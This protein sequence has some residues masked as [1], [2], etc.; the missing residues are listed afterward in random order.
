MRRRKKRGIDRELDLQIVPLEPRFVLN[1]SA[2][3]SPLGQLLVS[4]S[5]DADF[6]ELQIEPNG[7]LSLRDEVGDPIPIANHPDGPGNETNPLDRADV[8]EIQ[9]SM[10]G[11]N[12][13]LELELPRGIDVSVL[14]SEGDDQTD[15]DFN[16]F[17][18]AQTAPESLID[19]QS[20]LIRIAT[21]TGN[22]AFADAAVQ[23]DGQV[24]FGSTLFSSQIDVTRASLDLDGSFLLDGDVTFTGS[25]FV[26]LSGASVTASREGLA[27][28]VDLGSSSSS[29]FLLG[30]ADDSAGALLDELSVRSAGE[31]VLGSSTISIDG[32]LTVGQVSGEAL[33]SAPIEA[34]SVDVQDVGSIEVRDSM[35]AR[36]SGVVLSTSGALDI[37]GDIDTTS[38]AANGDIDLRG[39]TVRLEDSMLKTDGGLVSVEGPATIQGSILIETGDDQSLID[40]GDVQFANMITGFDGQGDEL[41]VTATSGGTD[42]LVM[43]DETIELNQLEV[44]GDQ[45]DLKSASITLGDIV[46]RGSE[47]RLA[48]DLLQTSIAGNIIV[49]GTLLLPT[50]N[51]SIVAADRVQFTSS[52]RGQVGT[53]E[54]SVTAG[55]EALFEGQVQELGQLVVDGGQRAQFDDS[56]V[57]AG[58]LEVSAE[59]IQIGSDVTT[60][61]GA[62]AGQ[63]QL[64]GESQIQIANGA[65]V[66]VGDASILINGGGGEINTTDSTLRTTATDS[67]VTFQN[68][69]RLTLGSIE[70]GV[71]QV[72]MGI[73]QD[74]TGPTTQAIGSTVTIDRL[75][76]SSTESINLSNNGNEL[77][78]IEQVEAL[79]DVTIR[80]DIDELAVV[81]IAAST[82]DVTLFAAGLLSLSQSAV[83]TDGIVRVEAGGQ[84][85]DADDNVQSNIEAGLVRLQAASIGTIDNALDVAAAQLLDADTSSVGGDMFIA[86]SQGDLRIGQLASGSGDID[87]Q[88]LVVQLDE[89]VITTVGGSVQIE[90]PTTIQGSVQIQTGDTQS[91]IDAGDVRFTDTITG[92]GGIGD[93]LQVDASSGNLGGIVEFLGVIDLNGLTAEGRQVDLPSVSVTQGDIVLRAGEIRLNGDDLQTTLAGDIIVDGTLLLPTGD[94]SITAA[95]RAQF[96]SPIVGQNG[97][98]HLSVSAT[99]EAL[100][101]GRLEGATRLDV[102]GGQ[103]ARFLDSVLLAGDFDVTAENIQIDADVTTTVGSNDGEVRLQGETQ[104]QIGNNATINS[105]N[106]S[107][108]IDGGGGTIDSSNATLTTSAFD[109]AIVF[110]NTSQLTLGNIVATAGQVVM[111]V[112]QNLTGPT[113]QAIASTLSVDRL[114]VSTT[115]SLE[116]SNAGND[117]RVIEQIDTLGEVLIRDQV[118]DLSVI[119]IDASTTNV[120]LFST[121][122]I[123]LGQQAIS[124]N[125]TVRL[126]AG[127][128]IVDGDD[129]GELNV[130]AGVIDLQAASV[131]S[132]SNALDVSATQILNADTSVAGGDV[133]L[134]NLQ[135]DLRIG[136]V[137][138]GSAGTVGLE[139]SG[140]IVD[141][142]DDAQVNTVAGI[143]NLQAA[144]IGSVDNAFD[145]S[146]SQELNADTSIAGGDVFL[147]NLQG[148][149]RI[150]LINAGTSATVELEAIGSIVDANADDQLNV[151]AGVIN[152]QAASVGSVD[153]AFDVSASQELNADT[154]VAGG[155]VFLA[156][157]QGDLRIGL[158]TAGA[159]A[160]VDLEA[161]GSIVDANADTQLNV[162]AGVINLQAASIGSVDDA[163]DV[164][165]DQ[166]LSTD[167]S[168]ADGD[169]FLANLQGDL[170]I[171]R[172]NAGADGTVDL[173]VSG[174]VTDA[175]GDDQL[176]VLAGVVN[177]QAA[178]IGSVDNALDV[179]ASQELN[180]DT[181]AS[182]GDIFLANLQGDL[183]VGLINAATSAT[184]DLEAIGSIVDANADNQLNVLAGVINLQAASI[185]SVDNALDVTADQHLSAGTSAADG[186]IFLANLQGD[187]RI[188]LI[189]AGASATVDLEAIGSIVDA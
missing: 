78:V 89:A 138:A 43:F 151:L 54:L 166:H 154:S 156:N 106:A 110:Q 148:D 141:A 71:G 10:D 44:D 14:P 144:S 120:S 57:L 174:Q 162:L 123:S 72:V 30:G 60:T 86:N 116:L 127:G 66:D 87:L 88:A 188:G 68:A 145:V 180:A 164:T 65:T 170:R 177:L 27:L 18:S 104:V 75:L 76:V 131:G 100:F 146:A 3:L 178:S 74:L 47:I 147:A 169:I 102:D 5:S 142:N 51:T 40:A 105:G 61:A 19:V 121:G 77:R 36:D 109:S 113:T 11:G 129:N 122:T 4:G 111:G 137:N 107:I 163:L 132:V 48:G 45:I 24:L 98:G 101:E 32:T 175:K 179:S 84:I 176:N 38:S 70:A 52:I 73:N 140:A 17:T 108:R 67:A 133:F 172:L 33:F 21:A 157:L 91:A 92:F 34:A 58:N 55:S 41:R 173:A 159:S 29:R 117:I 63:V 161:I 149:L 90:G 143:I 185:G 99:D 9:F 31:V 183:R 150:G 50:G 1:A 95:G 135:G 115:D 124:T 23:L 20:E 15:L 165:A 28:E 119:S 139:A 134:A 184:V 69:S 94:A 186:D 118:N 155:D 181:S 59:I 26:D 158:I 167:T 39:A 189:N 64:Q 187:L 80:D 62:L 97:T 12:D 152:L 96:T 82:A 171:S 79:G 13:T 7:D 53:Q 56:V 130:E 125:A 6:V 49:D 85:I 182:G 112:N 42:G 37:A 8:I 46:L 83:T 25:G 2:E 136:Q 16:E 103:S 128:S 35:I 153:N 22:V 81:L 93:S 160:T 114:V 168:A 126:E